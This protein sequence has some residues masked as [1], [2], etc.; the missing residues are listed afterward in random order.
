MFSP[1]DYTSPETEQS[2]ES[3]DIEDCD[4][5]EIS[6]DRILS[7][8][9]AFQI[10]EGSGFFD[11]SLQTFIRFTS[12][13]Q[14]VMIDLVDLID[15]K[16]PRVRKG[17]FPQKKVLTLTM[18]NYTHEAPHAWFVQQLTRWQLNGQLSPTKQLDIMVTASPRVTAQNPPYVNDQKEPNTFITYLGSLT[19]H[20]PMVVIE[21]GFS[22][23]YVSLVEDAKLW[24][25]GVGANVRKVI[26]IKFYQRRRGV[27]ATIELWGRDAMGSVYK[28]WYNRIFPTHRPFERPIYLTKEDLFNG[29][30]D[31]ES[32]NVRLEFDIPSL[33]DIITRMGLNIVGLTPLP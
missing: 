21:V 17:V 27:A 11:Q 9:K 1:D 22:Q 14:N 30:V 26:L 2:Q 19:L 13:D 7:T 24:L 32:R 18:P 20:E 31:P 10:I 4:F 8:D 16:Y 12:V 33:R 23:P 5:Q 15:E 3:S 25:E 29:A 28:I 6:L